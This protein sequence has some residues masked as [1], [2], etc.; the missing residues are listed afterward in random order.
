[1]FHKSGGKELEYCA[2]S[3]IPACSINF[4]N[5]LG[6]LREA[7]PASLSLKWTSCFFNDRKCA[8]FAFAE[9]FGEPGGDGGISRFGT[10]G[11]V[12]SWM[13]VRDVDDCSSTACRVSSSSCIG[14][15]TGPLGS[16]SKVVSDTTAGWAFDVYW[17]IKYYKSRG[18]QFWYKYSLLLLCCVS[19]FSA[20]DAFIC[21]WR[22]VSGHYFKSQSRSQLF[23]VHTFGLNVGFFSNSS[24]LLLS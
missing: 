3:S 19:R 7:E 4:L 17:T 2:W 13:N 22:V 8:N 21:C 18:N 5:K 12:K 9:G 6:F 1:M 14:P 15:S 20:C 24:S 10:G 16:R 23:Q 11:R